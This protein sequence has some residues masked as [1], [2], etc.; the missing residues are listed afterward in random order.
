MAKYDDKTI[1]KIMNMYLKDE[2][3]GQTIAKELGIPRSTVYYYIEKNMGYEGLAFTKRNFRFLVNRS[4]H[5]ESVVSVLQESNCSAND[6]LK[7]KPNE[8][9]RLSGGGGIQCTRSL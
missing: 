9:E 4:K 2:K 7:L 5:L 1:D 3:S 8:L 6:P